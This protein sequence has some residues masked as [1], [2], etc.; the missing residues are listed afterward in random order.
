LSFCVEKLRE[1]MTGLPPNFGKSKD[2]KS[3]SAIS[4]SNDFNV[5]GDAF[6]SMLS[7]MA[8]PLAEPNRTYC[9][10]E[11]AALFEFVNS[12]LFARDAAAAPDT[13]HSNSSSSSSSKASSAVLTMQ[14]NAVLRDI[15]MQ[16]R[17]PLIH[18]NPTLT[19]SNSFFILISAHTHAHTHTHTDAAIQRGDWGSS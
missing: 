17:R 15:D 5:N 12:I 1:V 6:S 9:L 19:G 16:V 8:M 14:Q 2:L 11:L 3:A 18:L 10:K 4:P 7:A 13:A